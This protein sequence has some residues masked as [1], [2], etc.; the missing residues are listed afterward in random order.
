MERSRMLILVPLLLAGLLSGC[1]L[2]VRPGGPSTTVRGQGV[3]V[4]AHL[5]LHLSFPG[6][7][8][9]ERRASPHHFD[10]V[11]DSDASLYRVYDDVDGRMRAKGWHREGYRERDH[12]IVA[13]YQRGD[14]RAQVT[15]VQEGRSGR[16]RLT[17]D[18]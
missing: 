7:V 18:D 10:T 13:S 8:V 2:T 3:I 15:V 4:W 6:V 11:F 14:E 9:V 17:I 1:S 5:G 16:Y 12:R